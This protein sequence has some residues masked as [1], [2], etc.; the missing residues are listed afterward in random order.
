[1]NNRQRTRLCLTMRKDELVLTHSDLLSQKS[2]HLDPTHVGRDTSALSSQAL[3]VVS[4][5]LFHVLK[6][7]F[8]GVVHH[9]NQQSKSRGCCMLYR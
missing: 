7:T 4:S 1:M 2:A 6:E 9:S 5:M 8:L 3:P